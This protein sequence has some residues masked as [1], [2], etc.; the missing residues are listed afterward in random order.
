[1]IPYFQLRGQF[2]PLAERVFDFDFRA[3]A[4]NELLSTG[5]VLTFSEY[6]KNINEKDNWRYCVN[7]FNS[8]AA[9]DQNVA[10]EEGTDWQH[11]E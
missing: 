5:R 6:Y 11:G 8:Q 9:F 1:M 4:R 7:H 3:C 2:K 10:L